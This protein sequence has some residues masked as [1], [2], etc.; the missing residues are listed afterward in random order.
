MHKQA[1]LALKALIVF[2]SVPTFIFLAQLHF[3]TQASNST[4]P[5]PE[6]VALMK[7]IL[8]NGDPREDAN[9][10]QVL[11]IHNGVSQPVSTGM[12]LFA[13][14]EVST[15]GGVKVTVLYLENSA[16]TDN[17]VSLD[18]NTR[19]QVGSLYSWLG[20]VIISVRGAFETKTA[21]A[22]WSVR[23]TEYELVVETDGTNTLR[24]LKGSVAAEPGD[25]LPIAMRGQENRL[26]DFFAQHVSFVSNNDQLSV[27]P[28]ARTTP[29]PGEGLVANK[30][31][32]VI[33]PPNTSTLEKSPVPPGEISQTLNWSDPILIAG[34]PTYAPQSAVPHVPTWP[35]RD[36]A[37]RRAR[38]GS[39][40]IGDQKS[41]DL[42]ARIYL[43]WGRGAKAQQE[44]KEAI[45][46]PQ[47]AEQYTKLAEASRLMGNLNDAEKSL[48]IA[49]KYNSNYA[50]ARNELGNVYL[51]RARVALEE[52]AF[53]QAKKYVAA[54][55]LEYQKAVLFSAPTQP[56]RSERTQTPARRNA[57]HAGQKKQVK[58][59]P[60]GLEQLVARS[61]IGEAALELGRILQ[62]EGKPVEAL[63]EFENAEVV[64]KETEGD[65]ERYPFP[66]RGLGDVYRGIHGVALQLDDQDRAIAAFNLSQQ[67]YSEAISVHKDF[68]EAFVGLGNLLVQAGRRDEAVQKYVQATRVRP[69]K[70][71]GFYRTAM[72]LSHSESKSKVA[73]AY[74]SVYL[75]LQPIPMRSRFKTDNAI[76][77]RQE[78][79]PVPDP[80]LQQL[81]PLP[82]GPDTNPEPEDPKPVRI[83]IPNLIGHD[84]AAAM[85]RLSGMGLTPRFVQRAD[86]IASN[87]V[88]SLEPQPTT[89][90]P[91]GSEVTVFVSSAGKDSEPVPNVDSMYLKDAVSTLGKA[92]FKLRVGR[93]IEM[94][95]MPANVVQEQYPK[96]G[97]RLKRGCEV[98]VDVSAHPPDEEPALVEVPTVIGL[99]R[100][101]ALNAIK[102]A[103][104][105]AV[106]VEGEPEY[107]TVNDQD[108]KPGARVPRGSVVKLKFP[109][110]ESLRE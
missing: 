64:F 10:T 48:Y 57:N 107:G 103:F 17:E 3:E 15:G 109:I 22:R 4:P 88:V 77:V 90:V 105:K 1:S 106:I 24:V 18:E 85:K 40:V 14:D 68:A 47:T 108:P 78:T 6:P 56:A 5:E 37:F 81:K 41:H 71:E 97:T 12:P 54:A 2:A 34:Q 104:L 98:V 8:I 59:L 80:E 82:I 13:G 36:Q 45:P 16:E 53:D 32:K 94:Y 33:L 46:N 91:R 92:G 72:V 39:I 63:K 23:G 61:N 101:D 60:A 43:D 30:L 38:R 79:R 83:E 62:R 7:A 99:S 95:D 29:S 84:A 44:L 76:R 102:K 25:F 51:D 49:L 9:D 87:E 35:E 55:K 69:E 70:P 74:A 67:K 28:S 86:C 26:A 65:D 89:R 96:P 110:G 11:V 42:L 50:R 58:P 31:D 21:R 27:A 66:K 93:K 73:S 19:V 20:R 100:N 52:E 75:K